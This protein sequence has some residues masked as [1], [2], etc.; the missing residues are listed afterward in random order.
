MH[1][2]RSSS[3]QSHKP[4]W[5]CGSLPIP[6]GKRP[7]WHACVLQHLVPWI[8]TLYTRAYFVRRDPIVGHTRQDDWFSLSLINFTQ[9]ATGCFS[10][11]GEAGITVISDVDAW[12]GDGGVGDTSKRV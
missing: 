5:G 7:A 9:Q 1:I 8:V 2:F 4:A 12:V 6:W 10:Y 3:S 11:R